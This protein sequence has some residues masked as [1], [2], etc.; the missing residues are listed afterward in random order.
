MR[1][2]IK[3]SFIACLCAVLG[4]AS[5]SQPPHPSQATPIIVFKVLHVYDSPGAWSGVVEF[6]QP[7]HVVVTR[8]SSGG[9]K[10]GQQLLFGIPFVY[11]SKLFDHKIY[12]PHDYLHRSDATTA[13]RAVQFC[14]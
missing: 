6:D 10:V 13:T 9:F 3:L 7:I 12:K 5:H 14:L 4:Y 8:T 11:P 2:G 1:I